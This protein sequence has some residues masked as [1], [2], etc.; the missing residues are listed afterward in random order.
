MNN[1]CVTIM[2][3]TEYPCIA[4]KTG[5]GTLTS[6]YSPL[7]I[8]SAEIEVSSKSFGCTNMCYLPGTI[9]YQVNCGTDLDQHLSLSD[10]P[11]ARKEQLV[12]VV[13]IEGMNIRQLDT[14]IANELPS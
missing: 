10:I 14:V 3:E 8:Y 9:S 12:D 1:F 2:T 13:E 7:N 6:D 4:R 11:E 5:L